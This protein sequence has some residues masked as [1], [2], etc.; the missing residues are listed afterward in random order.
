MNCA[1][2]EKLKHDWIDGIAPEGQ[3]RLL[4]EHAKGCARCAASLQELETLRGLLRASAVEA[5]PEAAHLRALGALLKA[6]TEQA[7]PAA[8]EIMT[9][10]EVAAFLRISEA[11]VRNMLD[12]VPHFSVAGEVRFRRQ[13]IERWIERQ[14]ERA[15]AAR[16]GGPLLTLVPK[17][18]APWALTG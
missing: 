12:E 5:L 8:S 18:G 1:E 6:A 3:G 11:K 16:V 14:E 13:S 2:F 17:E 10:A 9:L 15:A 7:E 4:E